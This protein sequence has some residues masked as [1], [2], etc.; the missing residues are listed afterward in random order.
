MFF[1]FLV[2]ACLGL[3]YIGGKPPEGWYVVIGRLLTVYYFA[4]FLI[5]LPLL[6]WLEKPLPLP[7]SITEAVLS[8]KAGGSL[9]PAGSSN[10]PGRGA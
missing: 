5:I 4:H 9:A 1:W 7:A 2:V 8:K 3:G 10:T 6:G